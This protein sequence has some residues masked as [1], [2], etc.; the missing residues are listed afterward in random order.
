M[1]KN[2][3]LLILLL[4]LSGTELFG[5]Q[6]AQ[7][8]QYMYNTMS[9]NPAYAGSRGYFS[10]ILL[11]R[12]QWVGL[13]GAPRTQTLALHSPVGR[14]E[15]VGLGLS[16]IRD[17]I[18]PTVETYANVN[19]S[20]TINTGYFSKLAFGLSAGVDVLDVDFTL[21][22]IY[23]G[24]DPFGAQ[25]IDNRLQPQV[26]VGAYWYSD[27]FYVGLSVPNLL[28]TEHFEE[29]PNTT[30]NSE[31]FL[32]QE[33]LHYH[34]IGGYVFDLS[35]SIK[36][37]PAALAKVVSGSP[38][39]VDLSANFLINERATLGAAYRWDAAV[40]LLAGFQVNDQWMIGLAYDR[41]TT[42]LGR[43]EFND[44]SFE[45]FL[46]FELFRNVDRLITPRF[47]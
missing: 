11:H 22:N 38:L 8:T 21:L 47:F 30:N 10:S 15:K 3:F 27:K 5:Q 34:I 45:V 42:E 37:K 43:R 17:D 39:Q 46:R 14:S 20:Y 13:D 31:S 29:S 26:G 1:R 32:A 16:I 41:E 44:G 6:D 12:S 18:G 25:N 28:E 7:Y 23:T 40:S 36:F 24:S 4:S 9:F 19:F 35:P 2:F 33:R